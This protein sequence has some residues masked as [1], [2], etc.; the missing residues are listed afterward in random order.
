MKKVKA[1]YYPETETL[2]PLP[3]IKPNLTALDEPVSTIKQ[4]FNGTD[5]LGDWVLIDIIQDKDTFFGYNVEA[6][7]DN[8]GRLI[9]NKITETEICEETWSE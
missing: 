2:I 1:K 3:P 4:E 6:V 8:S 5:E 9:R 7:K